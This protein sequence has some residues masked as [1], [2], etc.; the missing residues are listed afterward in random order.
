MS[1]ARDDVR[2]LT[3]KQKLGLT[4]AIELHPKSF[5]S[6]FWGAVH[7]GISPKLVIGQLSYRFSERDNYDYLRNEAR[8]TVIVSILAVASASFLR[9]KAT[10]ASGALA[11]KRSL[12]SFFCT[13]DRKP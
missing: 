13:P 6:N 9:S 8:E 11:T 5:L 3:K 12:D 1:R 7:N 4:P 10:T 2:I